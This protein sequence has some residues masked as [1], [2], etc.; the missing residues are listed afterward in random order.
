MSD[1]VV[2]AEVDIMRKVRNFLDS[3][4]LSVHDVNADRRDDKMVGEMLMS[5]EWKS[6]Y[7]VHLR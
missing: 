2:G 4:L 1:D 6:S 7:V 3:F 5:I